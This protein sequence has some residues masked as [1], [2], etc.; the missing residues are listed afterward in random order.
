MTYDGSNRIIAPSAPASTGSTFA[1]PSFDG[2]QST[3]FADGTIFTAAIGTPTSFATAT[4]TTTPTSTPTSTTP[5]PVASKNDGENNGGGGETTSNSGKV[6][7]A[8]TA[9]NELP[10]DP[11]CA[12][13]DNSACVTMTTRCG[14]MF[15]LVNVTDI[16]PRLCT[17][18]DPAASTDNKSI[19]AVPTAIAIAAAVVLA[20]LAAAFICRK[21]TQTDDGGGGGN[22][23]G[24]PKRAT[25]A[26]TNPGLLTTPVQKILAVAI[27]RLEIL[28]EEEKDAEEK[29][30]EE[31]EDQSRKTVVTVTLCSGSRA[32][33]QMAPKLQFFTPTVC[34]DMANEN[35]CND[36]EH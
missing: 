9:D 24:N 2:S 6:N 1:G 11:T 30:D 5:T 8:S 32:M 23:N 22:G 14:T 10:A 3:R 17:A 19:A 34:H 25:A 35:W 13:T 12:D 27:T 31:E 15:G 20:A 16:C 29:G 4:K 18:C 26:Y 7:V 28:L 33:A 21:K 36:T